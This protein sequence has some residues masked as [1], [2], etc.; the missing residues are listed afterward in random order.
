MSNSNRKL[1]YGGLSIITSVHMQKILYSWAGRKVNILSLFSL[2][3]KG[4]HS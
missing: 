2:T 4:E 1:E 3:K